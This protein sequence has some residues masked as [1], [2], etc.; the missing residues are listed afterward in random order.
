MK[1]ILN[2]SEVVNYFSLF[3]LDINFHLGSFST[4]FWAIYMA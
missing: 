2:Y 4:D 3:I 1:N